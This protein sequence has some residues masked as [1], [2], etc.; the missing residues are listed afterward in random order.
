MLVGAAAMAPP[1]VARLEEG[2]MTPARTA[3]LAVGGALVFGGLVAVIFSRRR[4]SDPTAPGGA[5]AAIAAASL[6]LSLFALEISD[7]LTRR[8]GAIHMISASLF[9]PTAVVLCGLTTGRRWAWRIA[10]AVAACFT[11]W[12]L[13]FAAV[14]P[15]ADLKGAEGPVPWWGRLYMIAV[16]LALASV[17]I[18]AF[19]ALGRPQTRQYFGVERQTAAT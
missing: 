16:S 12:F 1:I 10:R 14:I 18:A 7:G 8:S 5:R 6:F 15:F 9:V 11:L 2:T 19:R 4:S 13:G 3:V 17:L